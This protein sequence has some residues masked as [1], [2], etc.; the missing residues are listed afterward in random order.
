MINSTRKPD[1]ASLP[2]GETLPWPPGSVRAGQTD[3]AVA[4]Y[5]RIADHL[6]HEGFFPRAAALH[7]KILKIRPDDEAAQLQLG[8]LSARQG[9]LADAK[10][11]FS[12][13]AERRRLR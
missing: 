1:L 2:V 10:S 7:K 11:Y 8:E 9:L 12:V 4:Q 13:V 3:K 5:T 6:A